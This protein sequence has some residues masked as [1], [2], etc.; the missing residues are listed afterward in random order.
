MKHKN[1]E[2]YN[3]LENGVDPQ[4]L[5]KNK[6]KTLSPEQ[7]GKVAEEAKV[8]GVPENIIQEFKNLNK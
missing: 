4:E 3:A 8:V 6:I 7:I 1:P 5:V 2:L